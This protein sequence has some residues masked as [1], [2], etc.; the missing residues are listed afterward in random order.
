MLYYCLQENLSEV[1]PASRLGLGP[2]CVE[3]Y[4]VGDQLRTVGSRL[5]AYRSFYTDH[6]DIL[7]SRACE[8]SLN[9]HNFSAVNTI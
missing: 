2:E 9:P 7:S 5:H 1:D 4:R 3:S 6:D 8:S